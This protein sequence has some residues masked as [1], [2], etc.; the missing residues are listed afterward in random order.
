MIGN[1]DWFQRRKYGGWGLAP[2]TWQ[3]W[4]YIAA[5]LLPFLL[6][7]A[8]PYWSTTTRIVVTAVWLA[9]LL[10]DTLHIMARLKKDE[11][12][13]KIEAIAERNAAYAMLTVLVLSILADLIRSGLRE[14]LSVNPWIVAALLAGVLAKGISNLVLERRAL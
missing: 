11:R 4:A 13:Y 8:L 12:E 5:F 3:A 7:Q 9:L 14:E 2:R 10:G 1:P 6:F